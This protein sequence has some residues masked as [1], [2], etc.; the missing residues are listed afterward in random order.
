M[1]SVETIRNADVAD[2]ARLLEDQKERRLDVVAPATTIQSIGGT[3]HVTNVGEPELT[4]EGVTSRSGR[5]RPN[6]VAVD[7]LASSLNVPIA[8]TRR[9]HANRLDLFDYN[10]N[11]WLHGFDKVYPPDRRKFLLRILRDAPG[12]YTGTVRAW[13]S[14]SYKTI[15][16]LD[17]LLAS[18]KGMQNSLDQRVD[19][20][21][22]VTDTRMVIRVTVPSVEVEARQLLRNYRA[23][24]GGLGREVPQVCAGLV[25]TNSEVGKGA[26]NIIPRMMVR[27][28]SNGLVIAKDSLRKV[29]AGAKLDE[30][31]VRASDETQQRVLDLIT[32]QTADAVR[33]F[34]SRDYLTR[35]VD[36]L[37]NLADAPVTD[38][39]PTIERV[40]KG[41]GFSKEQAAGILGSFITGGDL[42]AGGVMN[43]ITAY[44]QTQDGDTAYEMELQAIPA[45]TLAA[46]VAN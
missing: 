32:S 19:I 43:A 37:T 14:D 3:I 44:A 6:A 2:V 29:H 39:Q 4:E 27:V 11:G 28:C 30:G 40:S 7:G 1:T 5:F 8:Y 9:I 31:I 33:T 45:L 17:V 26:F 35:K 16:N 21:A 18:L 38:A 10:I 34:L 15:D 20:T 42:S 23:P 41:V 22:D 25:I 46:R 12:A 13:L 24:D 36:E